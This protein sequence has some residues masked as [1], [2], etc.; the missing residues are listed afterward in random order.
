MDF[1]IE[2]YVPNNP[3]S[4]ATQQSFDVLYGD[5]MEPDLGP[6][7]PLVN[8]YANMT[9]SSSH[10]KYSGKVWNAALD[11]PVSADDKVKRGGFDIRQCLDLIHDL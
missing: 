9:P 3:Q 11:S 8:P 5:L 2:F 4:R 10:G 6:D 1:Y 7:L